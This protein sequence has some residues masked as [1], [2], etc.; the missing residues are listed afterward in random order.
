M[1]YENPMAQA[2]ATAQVWGSFRALH[3]AQGS[4]CPSF[5][6]LGPG[7]GFMALNPNREHRQK[8]EGCRKTGLRVPSKYQPDHS[9]AAQSFAR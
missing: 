3:A 8:M 9:H 4:F 2:S 7:L 1:A 6:P 5:Q